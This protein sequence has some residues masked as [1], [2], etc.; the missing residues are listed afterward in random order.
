VSYVFYFCLCCRLRKKND[1][2]ET[3][4]FEVDEVRKAGSGDCMV[5]LT[6]YHRSSGNVCGDAVQYF[7]LFGLITVRKLPKLTLF[8][9]QLLVFDFDFQ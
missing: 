2:V 8:K 9:K 6:T 1:L 4:G 3:V 5:R 7:D